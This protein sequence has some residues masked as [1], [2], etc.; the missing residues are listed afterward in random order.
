M[1][2]EL[3]ERDKRKCNIVVHNLPEASRSDNQSDINSFL[4]IYQKSLNLDVKV[5]KS[6]QLDQKHNSRPRSLSLK[7]SDES[8]C[9]QV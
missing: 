1:A 8:S 3:S 7:L 2:D 5:T 4:E 6:I 9:N